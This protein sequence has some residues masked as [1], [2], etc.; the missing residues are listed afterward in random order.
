MLLKAK[1]RNKTY[2]VIFTTHCRQRMDLRGITEKDVM[3]II[4]SGSVKEKDTSNK[5]W[6]Y[7]EFKKR[8]NNYICLSI[9]I[10]NTN[11]IIITALINWRPL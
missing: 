4:A 1:F 11:L 3:D 10:E 9:S 7:K 8:S 5:Y 6:V 2:T